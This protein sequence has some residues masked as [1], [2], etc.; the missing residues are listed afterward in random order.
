MNDPGLF[1]ATCLAGQASTFEKESAVS[2]FGRCN[3]YQNKPE[4]HN[5]TDDAGPDSVQVYIG[6]GKI[7]VQI[8]ASRDILFF[9]YKTSNWPFVDIQRHNEE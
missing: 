9:D 6:G 1:H 4:I 7:T 2:K 5:T 8:V 3:L